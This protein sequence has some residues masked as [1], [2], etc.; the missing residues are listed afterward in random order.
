MPLVAWIAVIFGVSSIPQL[1]GDS[2]G[3]PPGF[4]KVV[5]FGEYLVLGILLRHGIG[6]DGQRG[7]AILLFVIATGLLVGCLDELYQ[8]LIPGRHPS[9]LDVAADAAG[10][11]AGALVGALIARRSEGR[12]RA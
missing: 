1:S 11:L 12:E 3:L 10:I 8:S 9:I 6:G 5:H 7:A 4:D 2:F